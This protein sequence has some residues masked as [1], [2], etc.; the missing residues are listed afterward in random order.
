[1]T[2]PV[3]GPVLQRSLNWATRLARRQARLEKSIGRAALRLQKFRNARLAT[4][5][6][7]V[8]ALV[9]LAID[10]TT[11][12]EA[13]VVGVFLL[14][15][16]ILVVQTRRFEKHL[17]GLSALRVFFDRQERRLR[18]LPSGR[19]WESAAKAAQE[20]S[21]VRDVGLLGALSLWTLVDETI[22]DGGQQRLLEWMANAR[23]S[24]D[25]I[26]RRQ[27]LVMGLRPEAW[28]L[29]RLLTLPA[30]LQSDFR[31]S[32]AQLLLFLRKPFLKT[33]FKLLLALNWLV[34]LGSLALM[35]GWPLQVGSGFQAWPLVFF[36]GCHFLSLMKIGSLFKKGVGLSY[37]LGLL[38][39]I[40]ETLENRARQSRRLQTLCPVT[41]AAGPSREAR[42]LNRVLAF[43]SVEANPLVHLIVNALLP[44]S[45]TAMH[46]LERR[47]AKIAYTFPQCLEEL[48]ELEALGSLVI[49]DKYQTH[50]YPV[51]H[52][53]GRHPVL[54]LKGVFHPLIDREKVIA[55]DFT[56][57]QG[58]S[59]GLITGSN[60]SGKST[61]L[62]TVGIN[63]IL[64]NMGAPVFSESAETTPFRLETCIEVSD[65]LRDGFSYFYAEVRRL[66][67]VLDAA[68][69]GHNVLFL[70]DEIFRGTNNRE[71]QIG[72]RAVIRT[73]AGLPNALGFVSTHD[74]EL[75]SLEVTHA[76]VLN[77]HFREEFSTDGQMVFSYQLHRGPCPTTNAL[78]IMSAEGIDVEL[79]VDSPTT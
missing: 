38:A 33:G 49:L 39:P 20:I 40:F 47:R 78:K 68:K 44:W 24:R 31:L 75:T 45:L 60:M 32:S 6:A 42:K 58:K 29:I 50:T 73:L 65:S 5:L 56:F 62:R 25:E 77:L 51:I 54:S 41:S 36:S 69:S 30:G 72:S 67:A 71:R 16:S 3:R 66:K 14:V 7:F 63:Q 11:R 55:N 59:L 10:H 48:A 21:L 22:T 79:A 27:K 9:W 28:F 61:F 12:L 37:H 52:E 17:R 2:T 26:L 64:A 13:L 74:L 46:F 70:I 8:A 53:P 76:S 35:T 43:M 57:S 15:F 1:M 4:G 34:W 23:P 18:G 19:P